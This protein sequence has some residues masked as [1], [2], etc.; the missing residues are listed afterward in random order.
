M[1]LSPTA[2]AWVPWS[3]Q[4][5]NHPLFCPLGKQIIVEPYQRVSP[6]YE[7]FLLYPRSSGLPQFWSLVITPGPPHT[8]PSS[9]CAPQ[10][11]AVP[12]SSDRAAALIL[13]TACGLSTRMIIYS[14]PQN[15]RCIPPQAASAGKLELPSDSSSGLLS[16]GQND[17]A[18]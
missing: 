6:A 14:F 1:R 16:Y 4:T 2:P 10:G 5:S 12:V 8:V 11:T 7:A 17:A 9:P 18:V 15:P 3:D 13:P